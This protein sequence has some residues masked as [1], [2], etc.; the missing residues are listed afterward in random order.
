[1]VCLAIFCAIEERQSVD[2]KAVCTA[3]AP[4]YIHYRVP[5]KEGHKGPRECEEP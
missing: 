2:C 3:L 5:K 4:I 1:M